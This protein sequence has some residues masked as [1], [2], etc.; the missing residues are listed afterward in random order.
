MPKAFS[1]LF[2]ALFTVA[3]AYALGRIVLRSL[4][5]TLYR[6]E[7]R[8]LGFVTG[9]AALHVCLFALL[10]AKL[11]YD[12][13]LLALGFIILLAAWKTGALRSSSLPLPPLPGFWRWLFPVAW[14]PAAVVCFIYAMAPEMSPDGSTYHLGTM[15]R[16]YREHGFVPIPM[17][18][19]AHL[20]QGVDV[21]FLNA[22]AF[23]RHSAAALVHCAFL[24]VLPWLLVAVGK[25]AGYPVAGAAAG[26]FFAWSPVVMIDGSSA[27]NDVALAAVIAAIFA[28]TEVAREK[29]QPGIALWLGLLAGYCYAVKYT[30][31][32]AV[33]FAL[34]FVITA[35]RREK[36]PLLRPLA[37]FSAGVAAMATPWMIRNAVYYQNPF[38]PLLNRWFP[39][40][41]IHLS[42]EQSYTE[43]MRKYVGLESYASLPL[44]LT[45]RGSVLGGLL[46]WLFLLAPLGLFAA[47]SRFGRKVVIA[48]VWFAL[49]YAANVG[50]RFLIPALPFIGLAMAIA[51]PVRVAP[52]ILAVLV[53]AHGM[54]NFPDIP[55]RYCNPDAW[56]IQKI[57]LKQALRIESE[58]S[59]LSRRMPSYPTAKMVERSTHAGAVVYAFNQIPEAYTTREIWTGYQSARGE[60]LRETILSP[61]IPD[62]LP[63][64]DLRFIFPPRKLRAVRVSQTASGSLDV[65]SVSEFRVVNQGRELARDP[66]WRL[67]SNSYPW[68][69]PF[70][71]D[72]WPMTRWKSWRRLEPGTHI[73]VD[74]P[75]PVQV[76][77]VRL[78]STTDQYQA[79]IRLEGRREDGVWELLDPE[80]EPKGMPPI[81][82]SRRLAV[83]ELKRN[84]V[85]Y[86][87]VTDADFRYQDFN[88]NARLWGIR[89]AGSVPGA[90]LYHLE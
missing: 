90:W 21:L 39:N 33:P 49:P 74:F 36:L 9:A 42:F 12:A 40:P 22:F 70:A 45:V 37:R 84:G 68:D 11:V 26:L 41:G 2:G 71:F 20:S 87:L 8:L 73:Q 3:C 60:M 28:V 78:E 88:E 54:S 38:S 52:A 58:D 66:R 18:M 57:P 86:L 44:E 55:K 6:E 34:W 16:F 77:E 81:L 13:S 61:L 53:L 75:T 17:N 62:W 15:A 10:A 48:A 79:V 82:N 83:E 32:V 30:A 43:F 80:P 64:R 5:L 59:W 50:T 19:Y 7:E 56:R 47:R 76:S 31:F 14:L 72:N 35:V 23:G 65:W 24:L 46:G 85:H 25:R 4:R 69:L 29:W 27:Y 1:I 67:S 63:N 89:E 51:I